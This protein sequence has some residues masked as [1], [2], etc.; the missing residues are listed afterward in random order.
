MERTSCVACIAPAAWPSSPCA[1]ACS[2]GCGGGAKTVENPVTSGGTAADLQRPGARH[3]GRAGV[4]D[5]RLGQPQGEQPLRQC[6]V[7]GG[8][9]PQFVRQDD[10]NL[11]Y[12]AANGS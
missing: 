4:Q 12:A 7:A 8:Q 3:G 1:L 9:S 10:V 11:A 6:H 2:C 5:Q